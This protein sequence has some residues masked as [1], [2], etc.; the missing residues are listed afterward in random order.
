MLRGTA[1]GLEFVFGDGAFDE[2]WTELRDR[3]RERAAFYRG[4]QASAVFEGEP[5]D[6]AGF[7]AFVDELNE[8]GVDLRGVYGPP[9]LETFA[10]HHSLAYL[11]LPPRPRVVSI[12][13]ERTAKASALTDAALSLDADFA[14][15]RADIAQRRARGEPSVR[16]PVFEPARAPAPVTAMSLPLGPQ[17]MYRRGTL[18]GGQC[19]QQLGNIV[20]LGDVNPGAELVASGDILVFGA[21]R[22]TAHAGAQ[23]DLGARVF[24]LDLAPTQL[25]IGALI[26]VEERD[27]AANGP[28]VAFVDGDRIAI[29]PY[30]KFGSGA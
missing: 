10:V 3:L 23:G 6:D 14:A 1:S 8:H 19:L 22:G 5:P 25:R 20:V 15:A 2:V 30:A 11:G 12:D 24:A 4:S 21:L 27:G 28:E 29:G 16:K 13:R 26:A 9:A 17:T 7:A 18:R